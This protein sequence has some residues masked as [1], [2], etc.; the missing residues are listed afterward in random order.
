MTL[1]QKISGSNRMMWIE[2][3]CK[4]VFAITF[5]VGVV[6]VVLRDVFKIFPVSFSVGAAFF[7][8]GALA[9]VVHIIAWMIDEVAYD[10][11]GHRHG[12]PYIEEWDNEN[13]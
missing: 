13:F 5:L 2:E 1:A 7:A 4:A 3:Q 12:Q 6:Y 10:G 11:N 9:C 8:I